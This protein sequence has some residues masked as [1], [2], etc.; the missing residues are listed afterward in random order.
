IQSTC[1]AVLAPLA[2]MLA[3]PDLA[4]A[5]APDRQAAA[6]RSL[7]QAVDQIQQALDEKRFLDASRLL[8]EVSLSGV[9]DPRFGLLAGEFCV[10]RGQLWGALTEFRKVETAPGLKARALQGKGLAL[11]LSGKLDEAA[12]ALEAATAEDPKLWRAWN[13]LGG[14]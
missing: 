8:D 11:S 13:A 4:T 2:L 10:A 1:A 3:A 7:D 6:A 9:T 5:K 14:A 12:V